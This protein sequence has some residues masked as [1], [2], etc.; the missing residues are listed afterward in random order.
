MA[1]RELYRRHGRVHGVRCDGPRSVEA[2]LV[3]DA[4]GRGSRAPKWLG[5]MELRAPDETTIGVDIAYSTAYFR[6]PRSY[7]GESLVFIVG[8]SPNFEKRGYVCTVEDDRL[9]VSSSAAS[10]IRPS[11]TRGSSILRGRYIHC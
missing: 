10:F 11:M 8:P 6:R 7:T 1:V 4:G 9:L 2:E 5:A 3:V